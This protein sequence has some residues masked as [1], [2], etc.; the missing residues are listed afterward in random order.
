MPTPEIVMS[1][2]KQLFLLALLVLLSSLLVAGVLTHGQYWYGDFAGYLMQTKSILNGTEKEF[3]L[4]NAFTI[5]DSTVVVGPVAYPWGYPTI[6]APFYRVCGMSPLCLK[7]PSLGFF[8]LFLIAFYFL[9]NRRLRFWEALLLV[10]LVAFNPVLIN[11]Q[12]NILSDIP[13]LFFSTASV[14]LIDRLVPSDREPLRS[15]WWS[16]VLGGA[17]FWAFFIRTNGLLLLPTLLVCHLVALY[18]IR[19][20]E[21]D[22]RSYWPYLVAPYL[23]FL[24]LLGLSLVSFPGGQ[25]S[26]FSHYAQLGTG[27]VLGNLKYYAGLMAQFYQDLPGAGI[28]NGVTLAFALLG[29]ALTFKRDFH[30]LLYSLLTYAL[31]ITWP[32]SQGIRFIFPVIPFFL[33]FSFQGMLWLLSTTWVFVPTTWV[34]IRRMGGLYRRIGRGVVYAFWGLL[35]VLFAVASFRYARTNLAYDRQINGPFDSYSQEMFAYVRQHTEPDSVVIFF[36]PRIMRLFSERDSLLIDRC[37]QLGRGD[38]VVVHEKREDQGQVDPGII[39]TC[40]PEVEAT[41]VFNNRRFKIYKL[42]PLSAQ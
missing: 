9:L 37:D 22:L 8:A 31:F 1:L 15:L 3:V 19:K 5:N 11:F 39:A 35:L 33:Y 16:V 2:K 13:F 20:A 7:L 40:N 36:K 18:R 34:L 41:V 42:T 27:R 4:H 38:Y 21:G 6:L 24:L 26:Y 12:D 25:E 23:T 14:L 10:G 30:L 32:E 29:A 17:I 28:L